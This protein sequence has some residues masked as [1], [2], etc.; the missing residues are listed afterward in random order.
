MSKAVLTRTDLLLET[1]KVKR[2]R[3]AHHSLNN[4][5]AARQVINEHLA[6]E[7]GLRALHGP[8][9]TRGVDDVFR[10]ATPRRRRISMRVS[11]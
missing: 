4:S 9:R 5:E 10:R 7:V 2:L 6:V 3:K 11:Q 8:P 1:A